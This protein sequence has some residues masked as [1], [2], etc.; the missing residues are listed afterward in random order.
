MIPKYYNKEAFRKKFSRY[1]HL[2]FLSSLVF[3]LSAAAEAWLY[4]SGG[5]AAVAYPVV[6]SQLFCRLLTEELLWYL[7]AFFLGITVYAP[8]FHVAASALKG[9]FG[10]YT[11]SCTFHSIVGG[12]STLLFFLT[13]IYLFFSCQIFFGYSAFC[14]NV[15]LGLYT[16]TT[17]GIHPTREREMFGGTL[18]NSTFFCNSLNLRF[19]FTYTLIF[20]AALLASCLAVL[21]YCLFRARLF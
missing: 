5:K 12:K 13:A 7:A 10:A 11:L 8:F 19:L 3:F 21:V 18:F 6:F 2:F 15:S 9:A 1:R 16:D 20:G 14:T 17:L 4:G